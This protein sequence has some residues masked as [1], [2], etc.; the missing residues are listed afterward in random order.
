[1][2][3]LIYLVRHG[4]T[5]WN[6]V[7][8]IQG[9]SDIP[10]ND[11][12]RAQASRAGALL[13]RRSW[14]GI[15]SSPLGRAMETATIISDRL[16]L[17][18]PTPLPSMVERHYGE[19]EGL[20][21]DEVAERYPSYAPVP[22]RESREEVIARVMATLSTLAKERPGEHLIVATHGGVIRATLLAVGADIDRS[23]PITNG[24]IHSFRRI[25][26]GFQLLAFNDPIEVASVVPGDE[27]IEEQ[28]VIE[29]REEKV[30]G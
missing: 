12:G 8:R 22:G 29:G 27:G 11:N 16:D 1:M 24:S 15:Y 28:N 25:D 30:A 6:Q 23:I 3:T 14:D 7:H 2:T 13:A 9:S 17:G 21:N 18:D 20:T 4:E 10:L 26:G 19:A 5:D